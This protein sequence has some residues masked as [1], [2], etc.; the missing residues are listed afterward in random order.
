MCLCIL[1]VVY[2]FLCSQ[3]TGLS[4]C[5]CA[6]GLAIRSSETDMWQRWLLS[7]RP[8]LGGGGVRDT[9]PTLTFTVTTAKCAHT[10]TQT[11]RSPPTH[12]AFSSS[13]VPSQ[14]LRAYQAKNNDSP[15]V[16]VSCF[17]HPALSFGP[18]KYIIILIDPQLKNCVITH[19]ALMVLASSVTRPHAPPSRLSR[20][21]NL[22]RSHQAF[23]FLFH[24]SSY[25]SYF[26]SDTCSNSHLREPLSKMMK[27][28]IFDSRMRHSGLHK[29]RFSSASWLLHK[30]LCPGWWA[31]R[32]A[33]S[34]LGAPVKSVVRL[35]HDVHKYSLARWGTL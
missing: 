13:V 8:Q 9:P 17:L 35:K 20:M 5:C 25:I 10:Q 16:W 24:G 28:K 33:R 22:R 4:V 3:P 19:L 34:V 29:V 21:L 30:Y 31:Y 12:T 18:L 11:G 2:V 6:A 15:P 14:W 7:P 1:R 26:T 27:D 32:S 23:L